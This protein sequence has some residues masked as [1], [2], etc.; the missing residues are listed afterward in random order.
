MSLR[1][2]CHCRGGEWH[3]STFLLQRSSKRLST[4]SLAAR[5]SPLASWLHKPAETSRP[6]KSLEETRCRWTS[7]GPYLLPWTQPRR[8]SFEG[9]IKGE[10]PWCYVSWLC[11]NNREG[12]ATELCGFVAAP[13]LATFTVVIAVR[14]ARHN[15]F[16]RQICDVWRCS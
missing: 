9:K 14:M 15:I 13:R 1:R 7:R 16:Y 2:V 8:G 4:A 5:T 10:H 12:G 11:S 3:S 6:S